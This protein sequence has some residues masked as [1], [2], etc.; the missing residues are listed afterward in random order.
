MGDNVPNNTPKILDVELETLITHEKLKGHC[1]ASDD[2]SA[3]YKLKLHQQIEICQ[4]Q[5]C[6]CRKLK[7]RIQIR[8]CP[9]PASSAYPVVQSF[10]L[11][12]CTEK[13]SQDSLTYVHTPYQ[14]SINVQSRS[15]NS[16]DPAQSIKIIR[17]SVSGDGKFVATL[18]ATDKF[19]YL[20]L[21]DIT[22][23]IADNKAPPNDVAA[24]K[25]VLLSDVAAD[26]TVPKGETIL[27]IPPDKRILRKEYPR[28]GIPDDTDACISVSW[29]A[30]Y[31][32]L[33]PT[34]KE[35]WLKKMTLFDRKL[36]PSKAAEPCRNLDCPG[37]GRF[38]DKEGS[39]ELFFF[40]GQVPE[41]EYSI[42]VYQVSKSWSYLYN[43]KYCVPIGSARL[44]ADSIQ[45]KYFSCFTDNGL[46]T[47]WNIRARSLVV[48]MPEKP[49]VEA[50]LNLIAFS[51]NRSMIA[52]LQD[53]TIRTYWTGSRSAIGRWSIP[54]GICVSHLAFVRGDSQLLVQF[55][56]DRSGG[57]EQA[58]YILDPFSAKLDVL[59]KV[60]GSG[61][62]MCKTGSYTR[63]TPDAKE[64]QKL[65]SCHNSKLDFIEL[66]DIIYDPDSNISYKCD[67]QKCDSF[68][69]LPSNQGSTTDGAYS[70]ASAPE[71]KFSCK[72][73]YSG[74][75]TTFSL[76]DSATP[77]QPLNIPVD[78]LGDSDIPTVNFLS[79]Q[80]LLILCYSCFVVIWR[81]RE[82]GNFTLLNVHWIQDTP[83][84]K[85]KERQGEIDILGV[86][87]PN[88]YILN[89]GDDIKICS[90]QRELR[91]PVYRYEVKKPT[92]DAA[93]QEVNSTDGVAAQ[94]EKRVEY[95]FPVPST[96]VSDRLN[97]YEFI[98]G[99]RVAVQMYKVADGTYKKE[100]VRY[101]SQHINRYPNPDNLLDCVIGKIAETWTAVDHGVC[102]E[103]MT[104]VL[105]F[106]NSEWI[107]RPDY[108]PD[109]PLSVVLD[110]VDKEFKYST[111]ANII[112]QYCLGKA[113]KDRIFL[114]PIT[115]CLP[116]L[117]K[118]ERGHRGIALDS[119]RKIA[120]IPVKDGTYLELQ[121]REKDE[122]LRLLEETAG[123]YDP[124]EN[125][126][127]NGGWR[128]QVMLAI[129]VLFTV[130][131]M[132]NVLIALI[133]TAFN[134]GDETWRK[135]WLENQLNYIEAAEDI[136]YS[137]PGF[138]VK[139]PS[140][141]LNEVY[142]AATTSQIEAY[143]KKYDLHDSTVIEE[144]GSPPIV[145]EDTSALMRKI[146]ELEKNQCEKQR[147][148]VEMMQLIKRH[149]I[150]EE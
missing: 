48:V 37:E 39:N 24:T 150:K 22:Q 106:E 35:H 85:P 59:G 124:V 112:I 129:Y 79:S 54:T 57:Q 140:W 23:V 63:K 31:V 74:A 27:D 131:L 51:S 139:H 116:I 104:S 47:I 69:P 42:G 83:T 142:F 19:I 21:W 44:L 26:N 114:S 72:K 97:G 70:I 40:I 20:D 123:V 122:Y 66:D 55:T 50:S 133:N 105:N 56:H 34:K 16:G 125:D 46:R 62:Y 12:Q 109:N 64:T 107:P 49:K 148:M 80:M 13:Q 128:F 138:R 15:S 143:K 18:S 77:E 2:S 121:S 149:L 96:K 30:D 119:F 141:F 14:W 86:R 73:S 43:L 98:N 87:V 53:N 36:E 6:G 71:R 88:P 1:Q 52:I 147:E 91:F 90:C 11:N 120:Y 111:L 33:I 126:L 127:E 67:Q 94:E 95:F 113:E 68:S 61:N 17:Y 115:A 89:E 4:E 118:K 7:V 92:D 10:E 58:G 134:A 103:L 108:K 100:I 102:E 132:L 45:G 110:K 81:V 32:I 41:D 145:G 117:W 3:V 29:D 101:L 60:L 84:Q 9:G 5:S 93:A 78:I 76:Q 65:Y 28:D 146:E 99:I 75:A 38:M 25:A 137:I 8:L 130:I 82:K 135:V 144:R 136:S